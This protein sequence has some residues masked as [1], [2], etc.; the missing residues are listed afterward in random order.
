LRT[1]EKRALGRMFGATR[2]KVTGGWRRE[3]HK[4]EL[5]NF[6]SSRNIVG[7]EKYRRMRWMGHVAPMRAMSNDFSRN[8]SKRRH[9]FQ[10]LCIDRSITL[11]WI[12][13]QWMKGCSLCS[14]ILNLRVSHM[15]PDTDQWR[16]HVKTVM[17]IRIP[18]KAAKFQ[19]EL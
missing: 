3:L 6:Y 1:S 12:I 18:L 14:S 2:E 10:D 7:L 4:V 5:Y 17:N 19:K 13:K 16:A 8:S 15:A 11:E 9:K